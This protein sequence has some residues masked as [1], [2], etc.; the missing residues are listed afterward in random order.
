MGENNDYDFDKLLSF[1]EAQNFLDGLNDYPVMPEL[2]DSPE[3]SRG[4]RSMITKFKYFFF[5][6]I[7]ILDLDLPA[8]P[9]AISNRKKKSFHNATVLRDKKSE[10]DK[11]V[12]KG[13]L[14][15]ITSTL[16][17]K[18]VKYQLLIWKNYKY[19]LLGCT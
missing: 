13:H 10:I 19:S 15:K 17:I 4:N 18:Q 7:Y 14:S 12:Y 1:G 2:I 6:L 16:R 3:K 9:F 5:L 8:L 11:K